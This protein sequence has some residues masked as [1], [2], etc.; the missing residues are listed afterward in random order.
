MAHL[1]LADVRLREDTAL[2]TTRSRLDRRRRNDQPGG[3][4]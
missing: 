1:K 2:I 3:S 4:S